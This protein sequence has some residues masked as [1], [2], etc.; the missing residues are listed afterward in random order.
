MPRVLIIA[1]LA[2]LPGSLLL[3]GA[4]S[5]QSE[6]TLTVRAIPDLAGAPSQ[7]LIDASGQQFE[8]GQELPRSIVVDL[9]RGIRF[10]ARAVRSRCSDEQAEAFACPADSRIGGGE[11]EGT[12]TGPLV[13]GGSQEFSATIDLFLGPARSGERAGLIVQVREQRTGFRASARGSVVPVRTRRFGTEVRFGFPA[14]PPLPP[15]ATLNV[16]RVSVTIGAERRVNGRRRTLLR[17]PRTCR[18]SWP[19]RIRVVFEDRTV[20]R[21]G[22]VRCRAR[23][24][25]R[26]AQQP[27]FTG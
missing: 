10:D 5:A 21:N 13:P 15:G 2:A 9:A 16:E 4:V 26:R 8:S 14:Q 25:G 17:N 24:A 20:R 12:I 27:T 7:I 3:A 6:G 18:G 22:A 19:Y 23:R 11:A 1:L